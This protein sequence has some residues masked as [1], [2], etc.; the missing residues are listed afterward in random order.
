VPPAF[1]WW[2]FWE[3]GWESFAPST[4]WV[5]T[6]DLPYCQ[7][8]ISHKS[9]SLPWLL[10][11]LATSKARLWRVKDSRNGTCLGP[12]E[13]QGALLNVFAQNIPKWSIMTMVLKKDPLD[14][15][16]HAS[17]LT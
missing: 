12:T 6:C 10:V 16:Q 5:V 15:G 13:L 17:R 3:D 8:W 4:S 7:L 1:P 14:R 2:C 11:A 9:V